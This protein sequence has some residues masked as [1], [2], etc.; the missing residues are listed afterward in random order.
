LAEQTSPPKL[1][2]WA[3]PAVVPLLL[4]ALVFSFVA[5]RD[6]DGLLR[7]KH[8]SGSPAYGA[9][10]LVSIPKA[11]ETQERLQSAVDGWLRYEELVESRAASPSATAKQL[12][13]AYVV[14][15][16]LFAL[17]YGL[18]L[19][20]VFVN[21][22]RRAVQTA[23]GGGTDQ[24]GR[25]SLLFLI[26]V[27]LIALAV[28]FDLMENLAT[29]LIVD[30]LW[31]AGGGAVDHEAARLLMLLTT[32]KLALLAIVGVPALFLLYSAAR[33][34]VAPHATWRVVRRLR[35]HVL[36]PLGFA[37]L[38]LGHEQMPDLIRRWTVVELG[39]SVLAALTLAVVLWLAASK[40]LAIGEP[41]SASFISKPLVSYG[42]VGLFVL[43]AVATASIDHWTTYDVGWGLL[44]PALIVLVVAVVSALLWVL[45]PP[46]DG[47]GTPSVATVAS[48]SKETY[49]PEPRRGG[50]LLLPAL[51]LGALGLATFHASFAFAI[52][53]REWSGDTLI[54][55]VAVIAGLLGGL[56][57][58]RLWPGRVFGEPL[59]Y[60]AA[61]AIGAYG[62]LRLRAALDD[63][64]ARDELD[65]SLLALTGLLLGLAGPALAAV[66]ARHRGAGRWTFRIGLLGLS[67]ASVGLGVLVVVEPWGIAERTGGIAL[68]GGFLVLVTVIAFGAVWFADA[69][70]APPALRALGVK[71]VPVL[72]LA[73]VWFVLAAMLDPGG[74]HD[75][76]AHRLP[77]PP[78]LGIG[79]VWC[80]WFERNRLPRPPVGPLSG[81]EEEP[82]SARQDG[83]RAGAQPLVFVSSTGGGMRAAYW[84]ALVLDCAFETDTSQGARACAALPRR[85]DF[86]RS[87][88]V[89]VAS[90][91][92]GG[93]LGIAAYAT[94]LE[95]KGSG[96]RRAQ[97]DWVQRRLDGDSLSAS[98]AWWL[99]VEGAQS[100]LRFDNGSDRAEILE[101]G[102]ERDWADGDDLGD[103]EGLAQGF[104][105]MSS[106]IE[107]VPLMLLNGTS[108]SDGC[109]INVSALDA[110]IA[111]VQPAP[112]EFERCRSTDPF[113]EQSPSAALD[114]SVQHAQTGSALAGTRDV[115]DFLCDADLPVSTA[116]LLSGRFP[117]VSPSGRLAHCTEESVSYVV[118][119]GY[120]DT[121]GAS[122]VI[123]LLQ[124]LGPAIELYN[125]SQQGVRCVVPFLV[126]IDNGV[127]PGSSGLSK[128]PLEL[129]VPLQTLFQTR[130]GR[131]ANARTDSA[132]LFTTTFASARFAGGPLR[133]RYA[134]FVNLPQSGPQPPLGWTLSERSREDL[135]DQLAQDQNLAAF[136]EVREW[137]DAAE[138][139]RLSCATPS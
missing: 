105:R 32:A 9:T 52:D 121:S 132:L 46:G 39:Y 136:A 69:V 59:A 82:C 26:P 128:R 125:E 89:F 58:A 100:F 127:D 67:L 74:Y 115:V 96:E 7:A 111:S 119:G 97:T 98:V 19:M 99:F 56:I 47:D 103:E 104:R 12:L 122:P 133:D 63:D 129:S 61:G 36:I 138:D 75:V 113:G 51:V 13:L 92:S 126:Q 123:E 101:R 76:R 120:L 90:G 107:H 116:A 95:E 21:T 66:L 49:A 88:A 17:T 93:S 114:L 94:Y 29:W 20:L 18:A 53:A 71:G 42:L 44:I 84:T 65:L 70:P 11:A 60:A 6:L 85:T 110:G 33:E 2:S 55:L 4:V 64:P 41:R 131:A 106:T 57:A 24:L 25:R 130:G 102:W 134:H 62:F 108:V 83:P 124:R 40:L 72:T 31:D 50:E 43:V 79:D 81:L 3:R 77:A 1:T 73:V 139:D 10:D 86:D 5:V 54:V 35:V 80:Q 38:L 118:D 16:S 22:Q 135:H 14:V 23:F 27:A 109:R 34:R 137:F 37:L 48:P 91:I 78:A 8:P 68:L 28:G 45:R 87:D 15:D 112:R 117:F 30:H